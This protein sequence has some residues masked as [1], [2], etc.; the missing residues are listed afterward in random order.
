MTPR[1][2]GLLPLMARTGPLAMSAVWSL[3]GE[4]RTWGEPPI[5]VAIDPE[6]PKSPA[7]LNPREAAP[8]KG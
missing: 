7:A 6:R 2:T 5:S 3:S 8:T 1:K 4:K